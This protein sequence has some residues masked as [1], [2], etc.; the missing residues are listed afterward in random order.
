MAKKMI[1]VVCNMGKSSQAVAA[2]L[3]AKMGADYEFLP[4]GTMAAKPTEKELDEA[5]LILTLFELEEFKTKMKGEENSAYYK[6][7]V[8]FLEANKDRKTI[9]YGKTSYNDLIDKIKYICG[10]GLIE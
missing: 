7:W 2:N 6:A 1:L 9:T 4:R 8:K 5:I 3:S 10:S